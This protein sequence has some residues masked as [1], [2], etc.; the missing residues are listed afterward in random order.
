MPIYHIVLPDYWAKW[1]NQEDYYPV[2][3]EQE[4][5]IH[6]STAQQV[7]GVIERYYQGETTL[8][9]LEIAEE[10]LKTA[11]IYEPATSGEDYPHIYGPINHNAIIKAH[12]LN[13][14]QD[15]LSQV[16]AQ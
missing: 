4:G 8:I 12:C 5:F 14:N 16:L 3:F 15:D 10:K 7:P 2:T 9:L 1:K 13:L 6:L 11:A